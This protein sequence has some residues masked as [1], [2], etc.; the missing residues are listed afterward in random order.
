MRFRKLRI[1]W[2]VACG[3][4]CVLLIVLWVRSHWLW[5]SLVWGV[6]AKQGVLACSQGGRTM[7]QYLDFRGAPA[8][9]N[10]TIFKWKLQNYP[11]GGKSSLP[12]SV[13]GFFVEESDAQFGVP[14]WFLIC[15]ATAESGVATKRNCKDCYNQHQCAKT[16]LNPRFHARIFYRA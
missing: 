1:A 16:N 2:S 15:W 13:A 4:A 9:I 11:P 8:N 5:D 14:Y 6:T 3:I 7:L 12:T 10:A